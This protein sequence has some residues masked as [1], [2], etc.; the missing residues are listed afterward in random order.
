MT[1]VLWGF[2]FLCMQVLTFIFH[3]LLR[4]SCFN[5]IIHKHVVNHLL[6]TF[7]WRNNYTFE[8]FPFLYKTLR[9][10][11]NSWFTIEKIFTIYRTHVTCLRLLDSEYIIE[12]Y[13]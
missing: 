11:K 9:L 4:I 10:K 7:Y 13:N 12:P 8:K 1:G 5:G 2:L 3:F 6:D